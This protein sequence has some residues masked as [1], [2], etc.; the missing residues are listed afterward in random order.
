M[1]KE[2]ENEADYSNDYSKGRWLIFNVIK[3]KVADILKYFE[4]KECREINQRK[5]SIRNARR[6]AEIQTNYDDSVD[7]NF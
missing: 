1:K 2:R 5:S 6:Q 4:A 3:W 7:Y